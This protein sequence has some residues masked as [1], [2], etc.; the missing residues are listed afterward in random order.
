MNTVKR[1]NEIKDLLWDNVDAVVINVD[2]DTNY[3]LDFKTALPEVRLLRAIV[4]PDD[5][6]ELTVCGITISRTGFILNVPFT[7]KNILILYTIANKYGL[8]IKKTTFI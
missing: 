3:I 4:D 6:D 1:F 2:S 8:K 5:L 7:A